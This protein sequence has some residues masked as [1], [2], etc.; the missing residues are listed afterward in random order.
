MMPCAFHRVY[1]ALFLLPALLYGAAISFTTELARAAEAAT[2]VAHIALILPLN[3]P[4]FSRHAEAVR[5]GF[6]AAAK[7]AEKNAPPIRVYAVKEDTLDV[8]AI[9]EQAIESGARLVV[10][11]LTRDGVAA[12]AASS[13]VTVPT[14]ALNTLDPRSP[15]PARMYLFGLSIELEA[16]QI[17]K[18]AFDDGRRNAFVISNDTPLSKRMRQAFVEEF[19]RFGG[20][21]VAEFG[22][23]SDQASLTRLR[24]ASNLGVADLAFLALDNPRASTVRPYISR[25]LAVYATSQVNAGR[26]ALEMRELDQVHFV[27]MPWVLQA[28]HPAVMIY[29][30]QQPG[31]AIE[32]DR[33]YALGID[34]FRIGLELLQ[35]NPDPVLDGVTGRI[36]LT[37]D[38]QFVRELTAAL[39]VD[40]KI[41]IQDAP[42]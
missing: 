38:Q 30:R 18:L 26:S 22:S 21:V 20:M 40:G 33:L 19:A 42:R 17:A 6:F 9:Y 5:Q 2:P 29:P 8:L 28:D 7:I 11:P 32:F 36:R 16:R 35:H 39:F 27:D 4:S 15:Q 3:S 31:N 25:T 10:G 14:L 37:R 24:N 23:G 41:V 34:A 13:L 1:T 12:L